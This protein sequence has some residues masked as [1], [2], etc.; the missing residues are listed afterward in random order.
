LATAT[1]ITVSEALDYEN[2]TTPIPPNTTFQIIDTAENI[3]TLNATQIAELSSKLGVTFM[4]ATD[5]PVTFPVGGQQRQCQGHWRA[6]G[7]PGPDGAPCGKAH[8]LVN[9]GIGITA[10]VSVQEAIAL[11]GPVDRRQRIHR[12]RRHRLLAG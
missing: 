3:E 7:E 1:S 10:H 2:G 5:G 6:E 9:A 8:A 11:A 12:R 4:I